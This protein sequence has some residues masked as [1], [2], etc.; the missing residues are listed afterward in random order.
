MLPLLLG[1]SLGLSAAAQML[2]TGNSADNLANPVLAGDHPDP[3]IIRDG[4]TYWM[5][6]TSGDWSPQF[7]LFHSSDLKHWMASGAIFPR[8]PKWATGSFWAPELVYDQGRVLVYYVGRERHGPLCVAVATAQKPSGPYTDHGPVECQPDGSIDPAFARDEHGMPFL[9]WKE[10]G[11][12]IHQLTP[13]WAQPLTPDLLHLTGK[14]VQLL[15]NQ[16]NTWEGGVVEAPY[17]LRH[18]GRFYLFYAGNACCGTECNY[19]EGVARADHLLGPYQK[20]PA[21][22][23]IR[24]NA[25]WKCPGHG[26][27]VSTPEGEDYFLYHAYPR[28][29]SIYLGRESVLDRIEWPSGGWPTVDAGRGPSQIQSNTLADFSDDFGNPRLSAGWQW[30]VNQSPEF[31]LATHTLTLTV[32]QSSHPSFIARALSS[33]NYVASISVGPEGKAL[34]S[35]AVIGNARQS[36]G[37]GR[38]GA[39]LELWQ[40]QGQTDRKVLWHGTI[41]ELGKV[42][43]RVISSE[44]GKRLMYSFSSDGNRWSAAGSPIDV[45]QLPQW[46]QGLRVGLDAQGAT[47]T[48]AYFSDFTMHPQ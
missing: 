9:I 41:S 28:Q 32:S 1:S 17:I 3:S 47:G 40:Q 37:L 6:S 22:P 29:G 23:I 4:N 16:P 11:N 18:D 10:D 20:D 39:R 42:E 27:A 2:A 12:S 5:T 30:P 43:L 33:S 45:A 36:F 26:S 46:D 21:N 48:A 44:D 38:L 35:L 24:P 25:T 19:A 13:L 14:K 34:G 8:Q 15:T 7:P 31:R